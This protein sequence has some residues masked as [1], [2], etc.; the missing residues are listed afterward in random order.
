MSRPGWTITQQPA[1][2]GNGII[3][4]TAA[5]LG[6]N[7][8]ASFLATWNIPASTLAGTTLNTTCNIV[9]TTTDTTPANN[10]II[11]PVTVAPQPT[12]S[13]ANYS[14]AEGDSSNPTTQFAIP[15]TLSAPNTAPVTVDDVTSDGTGTQ[16]VDYQQISGTITF[17]AG[18]ATQVI[19]VQVLGNTVVQPNRTFN[20][21]LSNPINT[22]LT[23]NSAVV[24][25]ADDDLGGA[26]QFTSPTFTVKENAGNAVIT[27][28][29][30]GGLASAVTVNYTT[31]DIVALAGVDYAAT[32]GTLTF[33]A[34]EVLKPIN[35]PLLNKYNAIPDATFGITLS[36][37]TGGATL[38]SPITAT[39]TIL[40]APAITSPLTASGQILQ[41]FSYGITANGETPI[42]TAVVNPALLPAGLF[43]A[44]GFIAGTPTQSGSF[45]VPISATNSVGTD[46]ETLVIVIGGQ[47]PPTGSTSSTA[48]DSDGD[49]FP[50]ELEVA[51]GSNPFDYNS[52][53]TGVPAV[54][55]SISAPKLT[56][57]LNF[58][59]ANSDA[60]TFAGII[61]L[62]ADF[63]PSGELLYIDIGGVVR[64]FALDLS[65]KSKVGNDSV[66]LVIPRRRRK[67]VSAGP[68]AFQVTLKSGS[69]AASLADEG[70]TNQPAIG[71]LVIVPALVYFHGAS[72]VHHLNATLSY[73]AQAGKL[74]KAKNP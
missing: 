71:K 74:G 35:V 26:M 56:I 42:T 37:P 31:N 15:V 73:T 2:G 55:S 49:G 45:S 72:N 24:T 62:P 20:I 9:T 68:V 32:T 54:L 48:L 16:G 61:T 23:N 46:I 4:A 58:A 3:K 40:A 43:F 47:P 13:I 53:P 21:T 63:D 33:N 41:G 27:V 65:G 66:K 59:K 5:S 34:G 36:T 64:H 25:I 28:S 17:N 12:M 50:D 51:V 19:L 18:Q 60:I 8:S 52:T 1:V 6:G 22:T 10:T 11:T 44:G 7:F 69:F 70:L 14:Q 38:G 30:T 29:R 39:V 67:Q 57:G